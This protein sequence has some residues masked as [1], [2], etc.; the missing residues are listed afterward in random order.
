[1]EVNFWCNSFW[2]HP[3]SP[4]WLYLIC[5][6]SC[7]V[8]L[9]L[10]FMGK[11]EGNNYCFSLKPVFST[12]CNFFFFFSQVIFKVDFSKSRLFFRHRP[13]FLCFISAFFPLC[14]LY[15]IAV[16]D[17]SRSIF[18]RSMLLC[19]LAS[20]SFVFLIVRVLQYVNVLLFL[21]R[22]QQNT[23]Q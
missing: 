4:L 22:S 10:F 6:F 3:F 1:M 12:S 21:Y 23:L 19:I 20:E 8:S 15:L 16:I 14:F 5:L 11:V 17:H 13:I 7:F 9:W 18:L 2:S